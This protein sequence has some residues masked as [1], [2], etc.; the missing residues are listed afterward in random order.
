M[1][2]LQTVHCHTAQHLGVSKLRPLLLALVG[3][4]SLG[5]QA[6][7]PAPGQAA[8]AGVQPVPAATKRAQVSEFMVEGNVSIASEALLARALAKPGEYSLEQLSA[9]AASMT[10]LYRESGFMVAQAILPGQDITGGRIRFVVLEGRLDEVSVSGAVPAE[11]RDRVLAIA[12]A[13]LPAGKRAALRTAD[14]QQAVLLA[15]EQSGLQVQGALEPSAKVGGVNLSV[16]AQPAA[17]K[18]VQGSV[19][20]NNEGSEATGK[21]RAG[22]SLSSKSVLLPGDNLAADLTLSERSSR[23]NSYSLGYSAPVATSNWRAALNASQS[24]YSLGGD[25]AVLE[26]EGRS[27]TFGASLS[28]PLLR[29]LE[30]RVDLVTSAS[31]SD[32]QDQNIL[33]PTNPR[34]ANLVSASLQATDSQ[35]WLGKPGQSSARATFNT[36]DL[37]FDDAAQALGDQN[38]LR[39]A[40]GFSYV[41]LELSRQQVIAEG[42]TLNALLRAQAASKNL[43]S[44][45]K[46]GLGGSAG[47]RAFPSGEASGDDGALVRLE[48]DRWNRF[49]I[50][51]ATATQ[52]AGV[53]YDH[54]RIRY[55]HS[56]LATNT[57]NSTSRSGL[58]VHWGVQVPVGG[59]RELGLS[60]FWAKPTGSVKTSQSDGKDSRVGVDLSLRF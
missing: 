26:A 4:A 48:L 7:A 52:R 42:W 31:R 22:A 39:K 23:L 38:G 46:L 25:F 9:M 56:P 49:S 36:G 28:Y 60:V 44:S 19:G 14:I 58:G 24:T 2:K 32:L 51:G 10:A 12:N 27:R 1:T 8:A 15:A 45:Y 40:G 47:V 11:L 57:D 53:F 54:G 16:Q 5:V 30:R 29:S 55:D 35:P 6:Q 37:S 33:I 59:D 20:V 17:E 18:A 34:T 3:S 21:L 41:A 43:D 13:N 50:A